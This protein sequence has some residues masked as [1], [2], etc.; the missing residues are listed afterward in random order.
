MKTF[1]G[2]LLALSLLIV[3]AASARA[4]EPVD[5]DVWKAR[6]LALNA[7]A[8]AIDK[9]FPSQALLDTTKGIPGSK[10][11]AVAHERS[12]AGQHYIACTMYYTAAI[13]ER[14][15]NGGKIDLSKTHADV[16]LGAVELK[17]STGQALTFKEKMEGTSDKV[18]GSTKAGTLS[19]V[20]TAM[21]F[22]AFSG[23]PVDAAK[24]H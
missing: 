24:P 9:G 5:S 12:L 13:A 14:Q 4:Q 3:L 20:E 19:P 1:F 23:A 17:K 15:G 11:A 22:G 10:F 7:A 6:C 16:F 8:A 18:T 21:V 2:P